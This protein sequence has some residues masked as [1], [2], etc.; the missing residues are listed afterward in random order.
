MKRRISLIVSILL[1]FVLA[2]GCS[3]VKGVN[4]Q[5][6]DEQKEQAKQFDYIYEIDLG[7]LGISIYKQDLLTSPCGELAVLR[8][9]DFDYETLEETSKIILMDLIK[10]EK[11]V[12]VEDEYMQLIAWSPDGTSI[13]YKDRK[14][15]NMYDLADE[16]TVKLAENVSH[17]DFSPDSENIAYTQK[18]AGLFV[19]DIKQEE[20]SKLSEEKDAHW[21]LWYTDNQTIFYFT[22]LGE[23]L[24][25][26]AGYKQGLAK[27]DKDSSEKEILLPMNRVSTERLNG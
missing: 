17:A 9:Y 27:I 11:E 3:N 4:D 21:P 22:D 12:L 19:Y 25:D 20:T 26:G 14:A 2:A 15:L 6:Q 10:G 8:G 16:K 1:V 5:D 23:A 7:H 24:G 13:L 18:D